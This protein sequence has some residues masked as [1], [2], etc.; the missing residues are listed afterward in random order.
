MYLLRKIVGTMSFPVVS[1]M[2]QNSKEGY[3]KGIVIAFLLCIACVIAASAQLPYH[4]ENPPNTISGGILNGKAI[5]LPKPIY[6]DEARLAKVGGA[7]LVD[8]IID[9]GGNVISAKRVSRLKKEGDSPEITERARLQALL[10]EAVEN[11]A[12][13][14]VFPPTRINSNPVKVSGRLV[15]NFVADEDETKGSPEKG[16]KPINGGILNGKAVSLPKPAYPPAAAAVNAEGPVIVGVTIDETGQVIFAR[17][18]S[19]HP[20]LQA[21][22]VE[23]AKLATF[24][25]TRLNDVPVKVS[26]VITYNFV[27]GKPQD[28]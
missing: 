13:Q 14:A 11:A 5:S 7:V 21:A 3:M 18:V 6:P 8:V 24:S 10:D 28:K 27:A 1:Y 17:A 4:Q 15:Y 26:G 23:A 2:N 12:M 25:P 22:A 9:E 19:G 16:S 20:L